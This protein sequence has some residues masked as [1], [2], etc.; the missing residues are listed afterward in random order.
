VP[1]GDIWYFFKI[2][3]PLSNA[4]TAI[5]EGYLGLQKI[6]VSSFCQSQQMG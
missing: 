5:D 2:I 4:A 6:C 1:F 3:T